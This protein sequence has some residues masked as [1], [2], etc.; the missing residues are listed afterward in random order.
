MVYSNL[1][2]EKVTFFYIQLIHFKVATTFLIQFTETLLL[3]NE[4][5]QEV[6]LA[7]RGKPCMLAYKRIEAK[8]A[9]PTTASAF[10]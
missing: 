8:I 2:T 1:L 3:D 6:R 4:C 7:A 10:Q 5:P 9:W